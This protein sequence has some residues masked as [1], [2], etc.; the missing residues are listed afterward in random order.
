MSDLSASERVVM[1]ALVRSGP[2]QT[3]HSLAD[4]LNWDAGQVSAVLR[5]LK[6]RDLVAEAAAPSAGGPARKAFALTERAE[7]LFGREARP[8]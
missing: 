7:G 4:C 1:A 6:G 5:A 8:N 3:A 2:W